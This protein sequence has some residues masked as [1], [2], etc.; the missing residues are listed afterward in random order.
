MNLL[1]A[2]VAEMIFLGMP[3][4]RT[5]ETLDRCVHEGRVQ[6]LTRSG[7]LRQLLLPE[8]R[9]RIR[10]AGMEKKAWAFPV[11]VL[12]LITELNKAGLDSS[13]AETFLWWKVPEKEFSRYR[14]EDERRKLRHWVAEAL[15]ALLKSGEALEFRPG[16]FRVTTA[17]VMERVVS[18]RKTPQGVG[19]ALQEFTDSHFMARP[20]P[21]RWHR[22][23]LEA[24]KT[25][26]EANF[27]VGWGEE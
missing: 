23:D 13:T 26:Y 7:L 15:V 21:R 10:H 19:R 3:Y 14:I 16:E 24:L 9:R 25:W 20:G 12:S 18:P 27:G 5:K 22:I 11:D 8:P 2:I 17:M 6:R 1:E 4:V